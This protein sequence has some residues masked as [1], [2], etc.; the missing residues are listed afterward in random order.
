MTRI[1]CPVW[2]ARS[3]TVPS[4]KELPWTLEVTQCSHF[5]IEQTPNP[6]LRDARHTLKVLA[7]LKTLARHRLLQVRYEP[8]EHG[9]EAGCVRFPCDVFLV[10]QGVGFGEVCRGAALRG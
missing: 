4:A 10:D 1:W 5:A 2:P 3:F 7:R 9:F 8:D 6:A